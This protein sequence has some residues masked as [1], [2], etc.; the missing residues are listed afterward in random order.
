[1]YFNPLDQGAGFQPSADSPSPNVPS[2]VVTVLTSR[3]T[4]PG[5]QTPLMQ[6][7][8]WIDA[9]GNFAEQAFQLAYL[10]DVEAVSV[11]NIHEFGA[12]IEQLSRDPRKIIIRGLNKTRQ[13][14]RVRKKGE[15]F[16][17]PQ[18]GIRWVMFDFDNIRVPE[19]MNPNSVDAI[20]YILARMP[21][22]FGGVTYY[23]QFSNSAGI[24][25]PDGTPRKSGFNGHVFFWLDRPIH[26]KTLTAYLRFHCLQTRFYELGKDKAGD[27]K[28]TYGVDTALTNS[29]V[30]AHYISA[31]DI[32]TGITCTLLPESRQGLV[33][34]DSIQAVVPAIP[35]DIRAKADRLHD[36]I[37]NQYKQSLGYKRVLT[38]TKIG[39]GI[40][41]SWHYANPKSNQTTGRTFTRG[42]LSSDGRYF[43]MHFANENSPGSWSVDH[44]NQ[45]EFARHFGGERMLLKTLSP[46]AHA[47][48]R[49]VLQWFVE[50]AHHHLPLTD[51]G[52]LP[53]FKTFAEARVSLILAP[54][55]SGK[56][57]AAIDWCFELVA[58]FGLVIYAA[59]TIALVNQMCGDLER[60]AVTYTRYTDI[61]ECKRLKKNNLPKSGVI[62]TTN[63]S[64]GK[65]LKLVYAA[66]IPHHLI[67]DE[68]HMG[69]DEFMK[70]NRMNKIL[71]D[72]LA[73]STQTLLLTGTLTDV[74]RS[75]IPEVVG[76]ALSGLTE[77]H[78]CTYEFAAVKRNP[79]IIRPTDH[80]D[81]DF[82]QEI[83]A[84]SAMQKAG[85][86]LPR[87]VIL[88][89]T[90][91]LNAYREIL[92]T[93]GLTNYAH[94]VSRQEDEPAVIEAARISMLPILIASPLFALGLNFVRLPEHFLCRFSGINA[95]TSQ[96]IQTVNRANRSKV[97]CRVVIYGNPEEGET[98]YIPKKE[99]LKAEVF[100]QL[101][102]EST[103]SG[104]LED[105]LHV[106]RATYELLRVC[107]KNS[108]VALSHLVEHDLIQNYTIVVEENQP[109]YDQKKAAIFKAQKKA[110][111]AGYMNAISR[112]AA[113]FANYEADLCFWKFDHL[114]REQRENWL[115]DDA[116]VPLEMKNDALGAVMVLCNL[117]NPQAAGQV[118]VVKVRRLFGEL[119]PW[120]S[121][122]F[123]RD[124]FADWAKVAAE[125][126]E[127][128]VVL[129]E[130][131]QELK[132]GQTTAL[133][134]VSSLTRSR[135]L[136]D[137][138]LALASKD[139]ELITMSAEFETFRKAREAA[140]KSGSDKAKDLVLGRGLKLL[141][142]LLEPLGVVYATKKDEDGRAVKDLES[143]IVPATWNMP[144][145]A[146]NLRRQAER[147]RALPVSL[148]VLM[149]SEEEFERQ[150]PGELPVSLNRCK[151]CVYFH[152]NSCALGRPVAWQGDESEFK[153]AAVCPSFRV[154]KVPLSG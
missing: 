79:L 63:K 30:Q 62:V 32:G 131:L 104:Q 45:P 135:Q 36:Q 114:A 51:T 110:S 42:K 33:A 124:A 50:I 25:K 82:V 29:A 61:N 46:G 10:Y 90:S 2:Q 31:P 57:K 107:E 151:G 40:S 75:K 58:M 16:D 7:K 154:S 48:V 21:V 13:L 83:E 3:P 128:L 119:P 120:T 102:A 26:G 112:K 27:P 66:N 121:A 133:G 140:R 1:M 91:K 20:E 132:S 81:S 146:N 108:K 126:T 6:K 41:S 116:R 34:K 130:K 138:F 123:D 78:F 96:V 129:L 17:E 93:Y 22:E 68:I 95:D 28:F 80:F 148:N 109:E 76:H 64:F 49:D 89:D 19:G 4:R 141:E 144:A 115:R 43:T 137:A 106:D 101:K 87:V 39:S 142:G 105:H 54:T 117:P 14:L 9:S 37:F 149:V 52:F 77:A 113:L 53:E 73:K 59:P 15:V 94:V 98:F 111:R 125:K 92:A 23:Y 139:A 70:S 127:K 147:L 136:V 8:F 143:P 84:L 152:Q 56:T 65:I 35:N 100:A 153:V 55:G 11:S 69:L 88:L 38:Q 150:C 44:L 97:P 122:Q 60:H 145:M 47:Y 24:I 118:K 85:E 12:L 72:G 134:L 86:V 18:E 71:E 67:L 74:Q 99:K 103:L 5:E